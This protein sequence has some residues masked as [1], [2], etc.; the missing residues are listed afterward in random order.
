[1]FFPDLGHR[2]RLIF[3]K[4]GLTVTFPLRCIAAF[5]LIIVIMCQTLIYL[6]SIVMV[7]LPLLQSLGNQGGELK[8]MTE[9]D[10]ILDVY[11]RLHEA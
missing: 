9:N 2:A 5:R 6:S 10:P 1:M 11:R 4:L 8:S 7:I 3:T